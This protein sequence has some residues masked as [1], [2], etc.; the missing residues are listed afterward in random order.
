M[1]KILG[2][3]T[4]LPC[5]V[6]ADAEGRAKLIIKEEGIPAG[7]E[8]AKEVFHK[9]DP[10]LK[11]EVFIEDGAHVKPG[12]VAFVAEGTPLLQTERLVLNI[13]HA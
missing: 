1:P 11:M 10:T 4:V 9:F 8:V 7:V 12:D 3:E 2:K 13:M 5:V 6:F